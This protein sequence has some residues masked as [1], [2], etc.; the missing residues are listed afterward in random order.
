MTVLK[1]YPV[2]THRMPLIPPP[3]LGDWDRPPGCTCAEHRRALACYEG[4]HHDSDWRE[5]ASHKTPGGTIAGAVI[6]LMSGA[7]VLTLVV[8]AVMAAQK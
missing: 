2:P 3:P 8:L 1:L 4:C 5:R 7:G 6:V